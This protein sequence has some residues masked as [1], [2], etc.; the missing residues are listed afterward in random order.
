M[1]KEASFVLDIVLPVCKCLCKRAYMCVCVSV[2]EGANSASALPLPLPL[3][4]LVSLPL[5]S[6]AC[7]FVVDLKE[8][9]RDDELQLL[10][11]EQEH[12]THSRIVLTRTK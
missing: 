4:L 12:F 2:Y 9:T 1:L 10:L 8:N 5:H 6:S 11:Q 3:S 7:V